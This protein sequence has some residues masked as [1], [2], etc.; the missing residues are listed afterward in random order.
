VI[1]STSAYDDVAHELRLAD[2]AAESAEYALEISGRGSPASEVPSEAALPFGAD[3]EGDVAGERSSLL[4][5]AGDKAAG[6]PPRPEDYY[7]QKYPYTGYIIL[8]GCV[9]GL[10]YSIYANGWAIEPLHVNMMVGPG[11]KALVAS[12]ARDTPLIVDGGEWWRL[13]S[14]MWLH[15]GLVHLAVNM[16]VLMRFGWP[17][18]REAGC[19]RFVPVYVLGGVLGAVASAVFLPDLVSVGASGACF[20]IIGAVW[21]DLLQNWGIMYSSGRCCQC[22]VMVLCLGLST[23]LNLALG[24]MPFVD[25]FAHVFGMLGGLCVGVVV[26]IRPRKHRQGASAWQLGCAWVGGCL[27]ALLALVLTVAL[28]L[29]VKTDDWC[30]FCDYISCVEIGDLWTCDADVI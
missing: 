2:A 16:S 30:P 24:L 15:A 20:A 11:L 5:A 12:G 23:A 3:E 4:E 6:A 22:T 9:A 13:L 18:E 14:P 21:A 26:M 19:H 27:Y 10:L 25:N 8:A 28:Y 29:Q 1:G 17:M 7:L